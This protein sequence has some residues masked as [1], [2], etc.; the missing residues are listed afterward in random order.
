VSRPLDAGLKNLVLIFLPPGQQW[1]TLRRFT[2]DQ[3]FLDLPGSAGFIHFAAQLGKEWGSAR[4][5]FVARG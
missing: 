5:R 3:P 4:Y 1:R 2:I